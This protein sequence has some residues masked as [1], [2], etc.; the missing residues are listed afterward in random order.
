MG[1]NFNTKKKKIAIVTMIAIFI[2]LILFRPY[3]V[4]NGSYYARFDQLTATLHINSFLFGYV[5]TFRMTEY[6]VVQPDEIVQISTGAFIWI[7][8]VITHGIRHGIRRAGY[9]R[10]FGPNSGP[11][12][13]MHYGG[14][15]EYHHSV[16]VEGQGGFQFV[17][18]ISYQ[19]D[20]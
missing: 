3:H 1:L 14:S 11:W 10:V 17:Q 6:S 20:E 19:L 9:I 5:G 4:L 2:Y 15:N 7:P 8:D 18:E 13:R 16:R 12:V